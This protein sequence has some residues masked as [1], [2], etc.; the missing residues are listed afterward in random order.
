MNKPRASVITSI[1]NGEKF[2]H[3]F[4]QNVINQDCINDIEVLL[5]DANSSDSTEEIISQYQHKSIIYH[6]F[7]ERHSVTETL[8]KGI[9]ISCSDILTIWCVD[10]RRSDLSLNKQISYMANNPSCD[11]CYGYTA[12]SFKENE[13]FIDNDLSQIY[14]CLPVTS[15]TMMTHNSPHCMPLWKK[16]L[17]QK[18]GYFDG[19]YPT[20]SDYEFWFRCLEG[21][22]RFDKFYE[23]VG[24]YYY[25]PNG[26]STNNSSSN[27]AES[28]TIRAKYNHLLNEKKIN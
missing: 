6:K 22:A 18:F 8:N 15:E 24:S 12:W 14:P 10:D 25:N 7:N 17:N 27:S 23:V 11:I 19:S 1:Y 26:L 13:A 9:D 3:Q 4:L 16:N 28:S 21:G 2:L 5:L 20:A